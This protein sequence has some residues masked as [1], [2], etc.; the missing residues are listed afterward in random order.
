LSTDSRINEGSPANHHEDR[1]K[2]N[3]GSHVYVLQRTEVGL[4]KSLPGL[5]RTSSWIHCRV[6]GSE[7]VAVFEQPA[8]SIRN[9]GDPISSQRAPLKQ[10][11]AVAH[12]GANHNPDQQWTV[13]STLLRP[14]SARVFSTSV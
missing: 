6:R 2:A 7:R 1:R 13:L 10:R 5:S 4:V 14:P 12:L 8:K 3:A 11:V 9:D